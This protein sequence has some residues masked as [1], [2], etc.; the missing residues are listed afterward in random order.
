[1]PPA[2]AAV[3]PCALTSYGTPQSRVNTIMENW[4]PMWPKKPS[5]V[6]GRRQTARTAPRISRIDVPDG[7]GTA[8]PGGRVP[9]HGE[10]E[11]GHQG[12]GQRPRP[13]TPTASPRRAAAHANGS[14][15]STCPSWQRM[16]VT[17]TTSGTRRAG[18]HRGT[19]AS[20]AV[21]TDGVAEADEHPG[22]HGRRQV[23]RDG[24]QELA[25]G[26]QHAADH[27]HRAGAEPVH[28]EARRD[29]GREVHRHLHEDERRQ[30]AGGDR[31]PR[32]RRR[33]RRCR[34]S[35]AA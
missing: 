17:W 15:E 25:G 1:M 5:R 33:A 10:H 16:V 13:R 30:R 35:C 18:N 4:V 29:L 6:P 20:T 23:G 11:H 12:A 28:R 26:Q 19:S 31:E 9:H 22:E 21:N 3:R 34:T 24:E 7:R 14:A 27:E 8:T 2:S 32:R